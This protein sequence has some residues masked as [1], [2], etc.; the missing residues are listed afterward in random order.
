MSDSP[1]PADSF[2]ALF[3]RHHRQVYRFVAVLLPDRDAAEEAFQQTCYVLLNS[4]DKYDPTRDFLA[5]AYGIARNVVRTQLRARRKAPL[6]LSD[7][8]LNRLAEL[9][10]QTSRESDDRLTALGGCL[11]KL[12]VHQ[13][14]LLDTC[15]IGGEPIRAVAKRLHLEPSALYKRLDRIRWKLL[16]CIER[17]VPREEHS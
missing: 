4:R 15:Y 11:K 10:E 12:P 6:E 16:A 5:W 13:R 14:E 2:N 8:L 17:A 9:Q 1:K 7:G 3:T